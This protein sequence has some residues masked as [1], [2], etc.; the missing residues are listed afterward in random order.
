MHQCAHHDHSHG[1]YGRAFAIGVVLN[2]IFVVIE[3]AYGWWADSLA[4]L[5]DAGHN[6][7]DVLGLL[8]AWGGYALGQTAT[9]FAERT[10]G[11]RGTT[12][13]AASIQR[14][15]FAGRGGRHRLGSDWTNQ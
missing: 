8:M 10:Y 3:A 1:N 5:A 14:L 7:S 4:L 15:S 12:I 2:V 6:L 11:W 9:R 13:L